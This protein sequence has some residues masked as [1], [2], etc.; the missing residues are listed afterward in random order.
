[1][2]VVQRVPEWQH[3]RA[4]EGL[5]TVMAC[6]GAAQLSATTVAANL[7]PKRVGPE[8]VRSVAADLVRAVPLV[9][10]PAE[11][12]DVGSARRAAGSA[13]TGRRDWLALGGNLM[14]TTCCNR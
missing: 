6:A 12:H 10:E 7:C 14:D 4:R 2:C 8:R 11:L 5:V 1:M 3:R 9:S 13:R